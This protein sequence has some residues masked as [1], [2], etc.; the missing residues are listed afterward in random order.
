MKYS[1]DLFQLIQSL[2]QAEKRYIKL[3]LGAFSSKGID[4]QLAL[5][6]AM[7]KQKEFDEDK[8]RE[9]LEELIPF[10]NFHVAKN[11][12]YKKIL[13]AL[14]LFHDKNSDIEQINQTLYQSKILFQKRL[15]KQAEAL[16]LKAREKSLKTERFPLTIMSYYNEIITL[17]ERRDMSSIQGFINRNLE[18]EYDALEKCKNDI[19]YQFLQLQF[20][21]MTYK[22]VNVRNTEE[23]ASI[24]E[25]KEHPFL[26]TEEFANTERARELYLRLNGFIY[27]YDGDYDKAIS[28]WAELVPKSKDFSKY[29]K[30]DLSG[31]IINQN[32]LM[33]LQVE[34]KKFED[35]WKGFT[36]FKQLLS[37]PN[38]LNNA[39][40]LQK[41]K[42]VHISFSVGYHILSYQYDKGLEF[43]VEH[44]EYIVETYKNVKGY[45]RI[46]NLYLIIIT[47][48]ANG[49]LEEASSRI[50]DLL[51]NKGV[52]RHP[53]IHTGTMI[54]KLLV[55]LELKNHQLLESL[56]L[57]TYQT[58]YK[59]KLTYK[60]ESIIFRHLKRYLRVSNRD[61]IHQT[62]FSLKK[63]LIA[64]RE[65][66]FE[67]N[68]MPSF[69]L[70]VW[71]ESRI[72]NKTMLEIAQ[73]DGLSLW[74]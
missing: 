39:F 20:L 40:I 49:L 1:D 44:Q 58:M 17:L 7:S 6:N 34:A 14:Y 69:D 18:E 26:K 53:H 56:V 30:S 3:F 64:L 35:A 66:K 4:T 11:R 72:Q 68:C 33:Y 71:A 37:T 12:L 28:Y 61:D 50:E 63:E 57:S 42:E 62:F 24:K 10:K 51:A 25:L 13:K 5:L 55:H 38:V 70:I 52:K 32:N 23:E 48:F 27:R 22:Q 16:N 8:I 21:S 73:S 46:L 36:E 74:G 65:D 67:R 54:L 41:A 45:S 2:T 19:T 59:R 15:Y 31:Y 47:Y 43:V 60:T 29:T 9:D